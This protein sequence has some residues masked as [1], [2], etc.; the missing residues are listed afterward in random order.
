MSSASSASGTPSPGSG[1][2]GGSVSSGGNGGPASIGRPRSEEASRTI[3]EATLSLIARNGFAALRIDEIA[4]VAGV[5]KTTIYRRW[6]SKL[7]LAADAFKEL[8]DLPPPDRG[9]LLGDLTALVT[10]L[11]ELFEKAPLA[12]VLPALAAE[13]SRNAEL[14][15]IVAPMIREKR[16]PFFDVLRRGMARGELPATLNL[17]VTVD[18]LIGPALTRV[19]VTGDVVDEHYVRETV[20]AALSGLVANLET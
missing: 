2:N 3:L 13:R 1:G 10:S 16:A 17:D 8:P 5:S 14:S 9:D 4:E 15:T 11:V 6:P 20:R 19:L 7:H 18:M 12:T